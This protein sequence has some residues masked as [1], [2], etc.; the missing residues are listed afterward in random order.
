MSVDLGFADKS[1]KLLESRFFPSKVG[2]KPSWLD[3]D[4][5]PEANDLQ[6]NVCNQPRFFL[7]QIYCPFNEKDTGFHRTVFVF[8]CL[9]KNCFQANSNQNFVVF[10]N[11]LPKENPYYPSYP[12]TEDLSWRPDINCSKFGIKLCEFCG[13]KSS[14]EVCD[15]KGKAFCSAVHQNSFKNSASK[16]KARKDHVNLLPEFGIVI[17]PEDD[18]SDDSCSENDDAEV[19]ADGE[20]N[21]VI[22]YPEIRKL[23]TAQGIHYDLSTCYVV[24]SYCH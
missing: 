6:C 9:S 12:P 21:A 22:E 13:I 20:A 18:Y 7:C 15:K 5:I 24:I 3:L 2:G 11:Q 14:E 19:E 1:C 8:I 23:A 10:R 17:E 4:H 16:G